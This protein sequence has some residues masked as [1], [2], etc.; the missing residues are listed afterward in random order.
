[1]TFTPSDASESTLRSSSV[2]VPPVPPEG[3]ESAGRICTVGCGDT[4]SGAA[5]R[6]PQ[7]SEPGFNNI[8]FRAGELLLILP[9]K[10]ASTSIKAAL[11]ISSHG[12]LRREEALNLSRRMKTIGVVRHPYDRLVSAAYTAP[13]MSLAP[14]KE[15]L[16]RYAHDS[17]VRP[18]YPAFHGMRVDHL[19]AVDRLAEQW[20]QLQNWVALPELPHL[21]IGSRENGREDWHN[22]DWSGF[23]AAY[24]KDLTLWEIASKQG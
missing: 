5:I 3:S 6:T 2:E 20:K 15:R 8:Y 10:C 24:A 7:R 11:K 23:A 21:N 17:H 4:D 9:P 16:Q 1:M 19:L 14:L 12:Y 22:I 13:I 18:Q